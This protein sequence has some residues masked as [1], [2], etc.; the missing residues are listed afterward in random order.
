MPLPPGTEFLPPVFPLLPKPVVG[1]PE[2]RPPVFPLLPNPV[3]GVPVFLPPVFPPGV[4]NGCAGLA[5][6]EGEG[7]DG[8]DAGAEGRDAGA[9]VDGLEAGADGLAAG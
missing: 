2:F 6:G 3:A 1:V 5:T 7:V 9:G 8:L 4:E